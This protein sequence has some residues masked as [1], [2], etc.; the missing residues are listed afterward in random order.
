MVVAAFIKS[1][2][3]PLSIKRNPRAVWKGKNY[4]LKNTLILHIIRHF[5]KP[6]ARIQIHHRKNQVNKINY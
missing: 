4:I 1:I 2:Y 5:K 3:I 6:F